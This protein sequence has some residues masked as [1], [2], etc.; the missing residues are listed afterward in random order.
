MPARLAE[1]DLE[2]FV[3]KAAV[4][5]MGDGL[6]LNGGVDSDPLQAQS[7]TISRVGKAGR[8]ALR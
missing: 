5:R 3:I 1:Q 7:P 8:P 2:S 4:Q 6:G